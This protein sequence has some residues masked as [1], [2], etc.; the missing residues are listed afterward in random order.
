MKSQRPA[1]RRVSIVYCG[2]LFCSVWTSSVHVTAADGSRYAHS[3]GDARFLHHIDLYDTKNRKISADS[4]LPY[5]PLNTC[6]RCHDYAS[7]AHGWHFSAL[8]PDSERIDDGRVSEPW[9][10]TDPRTGTQIPLSPRR[11][12]GRWNPDDLGITT[13]QW[14][15]HFGD[16]MPGTSVNRN[17]NRENDGATNSAASRPNSGSLESGSQGDADQPDRW[18]LSG[19]LEVDCMICH[20]RS[21]AYDMETRREQVS[22]QNFAWAPT[23]ALRLGSVQGKVSGVKTGADLSDEKTMKRMPKVSYDPARFAADGKVFMDLIREPEN[24]ACYQ[25]HSRRVV[26]DEGI[27]PRWIH[28]DDVHIRA[29]MNC[30]DCHRNGIEHDIVRGFEGQSHLSG[31]SVETLSCKG[32]HLGADFSATDDDEVIGLAGRLGSPEPMHAG[33][34]PLHFEKLSCTACHSGPRPGK[35]ALGWMTSLAH[36]LGSK[37]HRSGD[38]WPAIRGPVFAPLS[39]SVK[40]EQSDGLDAVRDHIDAPP[41]EKSEVSPGKNA[42][43]PETRRN[44]ETAAEE[45]RRDRERVHPQAVMWPSYFA[46]VVDDRLVPLNPQ[47]VYDL[48]RRALRVRKDFVEEIT[49]PKLSRSDRQEILGDERAKADESE[50]TEEENRALLA[51]QHELGMAS[52]DEKVA[53][54][55][56]ALEATPNVD[57]AAYVSTGRVFVTRTSVDLNGDEFPVANVS[58]NELATIDPARFQNHTAAGNKVSDPVGSVLWP[59]A[60]SVRGAG[61]ALGKR[62]CLDCHSDRANLF[63]STVTSTGPAPIPGTTVSMAN[64]QGIDEDQ[65]L[66]WNQMF[67]GRAVFKYVIAASLVAVFLVLLLGLADKFRSIL[68]N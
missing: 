67:A 42:S 33:L 23:A 18:N 20:A 59:I 68:S 56:L 51:K 29:G 37:A 63:V 43:E 13:F 41:R 60:H 1:R 66:R 7:I 22:Q 64:L 52:F 55:L 50:L 61:H 47:L 5:S 46:K 48:T 8:V 9:I 16:R 12:G 6:G 21:G 62:G 54:A 3:D 35:Q 44:L 30:V 53:K 14:V 2:V 45:F 49:K 32:C 57:R 17:A 31:N 36:K 24:N 4:T 25:C 19:A 10:W 34:P 65:R 58:V 39:A 40:T 27:Q 28:D 15:E 11:H 38:E 26:D